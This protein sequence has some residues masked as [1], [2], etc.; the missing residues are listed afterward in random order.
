MVESSAVE[1]VLP[2]CVRFELRLSSPLVLVS[3]FWLVAFLNLTAG[4]SYDILAAV[5]A[6]SK[7]GLD[8]V[9]RRGLE[10]LRLVLCTGDGGV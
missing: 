7:V 3:T 9:G 5:L 8:G 10:G 6:W 1:N 4:F 2:S